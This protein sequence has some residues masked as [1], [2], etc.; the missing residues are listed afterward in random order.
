[1]LTTAMAL[2][3]GP[4]PGAARAARRSQFLPWLRVYANNN[5]QSTADDR[6]K[7]RTQ[8]VELACTAVGGHDH[9]Q[10]L[11]DSATKRL[12]LAPHQV[13]TRTQVFLF[14]PADWSFVCPSEI[15]SF[16]EACATLLAC[17]A[18]LGLSVGRAC[19]AWVVRAEPACSPHPCSV[20]KSYKNLCS[21]MAGIRILMMPIHSQSSKI[22]RYIHRL[23]LNRHAAAEHQDDRLQR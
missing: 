22:I 17:R 12:E 11:R 20:T 21:C 14:Y 2:S 15:I 7:Q 5:S 3:A 10:H 9:V 18:S 23:C 4:V 1:M 6:I 19:V 13:C 16:N 8:I